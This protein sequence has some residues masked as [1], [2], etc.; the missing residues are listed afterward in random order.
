MDITSKFNLQTETWH[1]L[2]DVPAELSIVGCQVCCVGDNIYL[3]GGGYDYRRVSEYNP[4]THN[5]RNLP[6]LQQGRRGHS[7]CSLDNKM[8][9]L[10]GDGTTSCEM[11]DLSDEDL[12]W[13]YIAHMNSSHHYHG[14]AVVMER[15]IYVLGGGDTTTVEMYDVDQ[16]MTMMME[17]LQSIIFDVYRSME[18]CHQLA[19]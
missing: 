2:T 3:V 18:H 5:W 10:G 6:S 14:G 17:L 9:V 12:R 11:L 15:K 7:V 4:R 13:R 1:H 16:G 8:F 19:I